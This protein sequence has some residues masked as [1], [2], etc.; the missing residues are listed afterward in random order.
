[1]HRPGVTRS[2]AKDGSSLYRRLAVAL[3]QWLLF[4]RYLAIMCFASYELRFM[5]AVENGSFRIRIQIPHAQPTH[6]KAHTH[7]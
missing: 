7:Q 2:P 4:L 6:S 1:V 5:V 3:Q